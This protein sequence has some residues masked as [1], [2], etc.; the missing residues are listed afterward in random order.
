VS[1]RVLIAGGSGLIGRALAAELVA[2]GREVVVL[3]RSPESAASSGHGAVRTVGWD[4]RTPAGWLAELEGAAAVVNLAGENVGD[5]RW[6]AAR[7]RRLASSRL[8]PTAAI[9]AAIAAARR[10][11]A[12]L[13]QGS[14]VG[15]YGDRG[16][17]PL[18]ERS[19]PG[20]GF[21]P[22]LCEAWEAASAPVEELGVRR[23]LLRSAVVLARRG[24][25][26]PKMARPFRLG[27]GAPLGSGAQRFPWIHL[28]DE[29]GAIRFLL[30][31]SELAGPFNLAAP[32]TPTQREL[33][34]ALARA[35]RRPLWPGV[36]RPVLR[37]LFG[38]MADVLLA[39]QRVAPARLLEAGFVHRRPELGPALVDL[40]R[41]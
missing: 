19:R 27:L 35:L 25:A 5:G 34:R 22:E 16:E 37:L 20:R 33:S 21:L 4:G 38:E 31:R 9:A 18:D 23:A 36:P 28:D 7:K 40:L 17:E 3:S 29:V 32:E 1:G 12:V 39:S 13:L 10:R 6:T 24:G 11:P 8:E 14:A 2:A 15:F 30:E 41:R 26:L